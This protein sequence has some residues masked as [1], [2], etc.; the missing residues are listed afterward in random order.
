[1]VMRDQDPYEKEQNLIP[2][3]LQFLNEAEWHAA[4]PVWRFSADILE[5]ATGNK[6]DFWQ[7]TFYGFHRDN[8]HFYGAKTEGDFTAVVTFDGQYEVLYD[9]IG[10]MMRVDA[11]NWLKT[12]IEF[13]DG[14]TN[15]SAV[16]TRDGR[17]DWSVMAVP[18]VSGPQQVRLTRIGAAIIVHFLNSR[19]AWQLLR[20]GDFRAPSAVRLGP[21]ACSPEREGLQA[22]FLGFEVGP[23]VS[24]PLH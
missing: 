22:R 9:Q 11:Q 13:S 17:S 8:G 10:M 5:V 3:S 6:T 7:D 15:F 14:A 2:T 16:I 4:P 23:A 19:G 20:L 24:K 21:M 1:M 12:G 18:R